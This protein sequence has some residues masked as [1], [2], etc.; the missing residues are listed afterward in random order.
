HASSPLPSCRSTTS[1]SPFTVSK[2]PP[3]VSPRP[4][5][6]TSPKSSHGEGRTRLRC[7]HRAVAHEKGQPRRAALTTS[8]TSV[9]PTSACIVI[10][11]DRGHQELVVDFLRGPVLKSGVPALRI[12]PE[13]D[14]PHNI[15]VRVLASRI[16]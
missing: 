11:D 10:L 2:T 7:D 6:V 15:T 14:V 5:P 8:A 13:F 4:S 1:L 3:S 12:V 16:L 9:T